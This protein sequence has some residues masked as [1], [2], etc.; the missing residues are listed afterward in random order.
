MQAE[1]R[2]VMFE[3]TEAWRRAYPGAHAGFLTVL[4]V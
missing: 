2:S 1:R 3:V 4:D